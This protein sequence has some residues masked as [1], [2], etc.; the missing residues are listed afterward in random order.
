MIVNKGMMVDEDSYSGFGTEKNPSILREELEKGKIKRVFVVGLAY[1]FCVGS[2]ALDAKKF[3]METFVIMEGTK[4]A[5]KQSEE[6]MK[7]RLD[8]AGV[9][10]IS[11]EEALKIAT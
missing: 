10:E 2:T 8:E 7:K 5:T 3:G 1:D 11:M 4:S 9:K 6:S